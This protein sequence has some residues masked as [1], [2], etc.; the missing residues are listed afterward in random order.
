MFPQKLWE[1]QPNTLPLEEKSAIRHGDYQKIDD[2]EQKNITIN[3]VSYPWG[4]LHKKI[5]LQKLKQ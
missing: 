3:M 1:T 5:I 4:C 2:L